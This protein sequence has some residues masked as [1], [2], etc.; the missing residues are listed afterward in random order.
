MSWGIRGVRDSGR[1]WDLWFRG[2][3]GLSSRGGVNGSGG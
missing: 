1:L 2:F 3:G